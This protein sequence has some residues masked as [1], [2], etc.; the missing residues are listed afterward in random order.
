[1][2]FNPFLPIKEND[3]KEKQG[4]KTFFALRFSQLSTSTM[5]LNSC[6]CWLTLRSNFLSCY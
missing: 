2:F 6:F 3:D 5:F 1:M 4:V